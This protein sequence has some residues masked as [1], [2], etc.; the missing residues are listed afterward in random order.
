M[1]VTCLTVLVEVIVLMAHHSTCISRPPALLLHLVRGN[2]RGGSELINRRRTFPKAAECN[3]DVANGLQ[4]DDN[5]WTRENSEIGK[6]ADM[7]ASPFCRRQNEIHQQQQQYVLE[8]WRSVASA[9]DIV[10]FWIML[11]I[12]GLGAVVVLIIIPFFHIS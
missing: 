4:N 8:E 7:C 5:V 3:G 2:N 12:V 1:S 10:F 9:L 6:S 11:T